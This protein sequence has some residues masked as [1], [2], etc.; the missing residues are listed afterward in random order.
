MYIEIGP[1]SVVIKTEKSHVNVEPDR[2]KLENYIKELLHLIGG[3]LPVLRQRAYRIKRFQNLPSTAKKMIEAVKTVDEETLTPMAS[4]A[5]AVSDEI[6]AYLKKEGFD[7]ISVNNGGDI[8]IFNKDLEKSTKVSIG[9]VNKNI[10]TPYILNI[11]GIKDY[12]IATSGLGGRSFTLGIAEIGTVIAETGAIA[13]AAATYIC[14]KTDVVSKNVLKEKASVIDPTTDIPHEYV[15]IDISKLNQ[16]EANIA[17][18]NG[19]KIAYNLK[20][21]K[22][23][24]DAFIFLKGNMVTTITGDKNIKLEVSHGN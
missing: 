3:C 14:N 17:L 4:V 13:D 1:V 12:G 20:E 18:Q 9:H 19:L 24:F 22:K 5:G 10:H 15:T 16:E 21:E 11:K 6:K 23:I 8:S 7:F 2:S